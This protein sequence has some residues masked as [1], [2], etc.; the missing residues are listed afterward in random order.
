[1]N[2]KTSSSLNWKILYKQQK[3]YKNCLD[4]NQHKT[5][6]NRKKTGKKCLDHNQHKT[7]KKQEKK[8]KKAGKKQE[9][10]RKKTFFFLIS[11]YITYF[12]IKYNLIFV[13]D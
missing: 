2:W 3:Q 1:M 10:N 6:K 5:G 12:W 7:G 4:H 13:A 8:Q 9:K 11:G